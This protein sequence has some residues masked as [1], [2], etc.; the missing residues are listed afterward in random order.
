MKCSAWSSLGISVCSTLVL[1]A[2]AVA[3]V[4]ISPRRI[5]PGTTTRLVVWVTNDTKT[6]ITGVAI[7]LPADFQLA[8]AEA[9]GSWKTS[10]HARTATW[11]GYKIGP[12]QFAFFTLTVRTPAMQERG[13]FS[14]LAS[15][16]S[17]S[18]AT[19][20]ASVNVFPAQPTRDKGARLTAT[21]ALIVA[22]IATLLALAGGIL[23]LWLWLRPRPEAF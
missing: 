15:K 3:G 23:A 10:V 22:S 16:A 8:E 20:Q 21:I 2:P 14:I 9:K 18:T 7:G 17:G 4:D 5:D 1:A 6:A 12:G 13:L 11:E 19:W